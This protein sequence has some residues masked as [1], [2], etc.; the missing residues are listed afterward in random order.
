MTE[1]VAPFPLPALSARMVP[2]WASTRWRAS[3]PSWR[4]AEERRELAVGFRLH[5]A[6]PLEIGVLVNAVAKLAGRTS[7]TTAM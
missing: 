5:L 2:P 7:G 1:N 4:L 3:I 6:K